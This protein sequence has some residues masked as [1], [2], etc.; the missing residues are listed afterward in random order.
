LQKIFVA[1]CCHVE[2]VDYVHVVVLGK[3]SQAHRVP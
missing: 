2:G 1:C 3:C